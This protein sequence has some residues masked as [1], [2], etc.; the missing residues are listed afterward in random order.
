MECFKYL[1]LILFELCQNKK[2]SLMRNRYF[3][4]VI[5]LK[6]YVALEFTLYFL[7]NPSEKNL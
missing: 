1:Q 2:H 5:Y 6:M 3:T 4:S 7:L